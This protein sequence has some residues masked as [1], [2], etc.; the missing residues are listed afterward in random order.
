MGLAAA[1]KHDVAV[2]HVEL[3]VASPGAPGFYEGGGPG[4]SIT[5]S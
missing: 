1:A 2:A 3:A 5:P 4:G